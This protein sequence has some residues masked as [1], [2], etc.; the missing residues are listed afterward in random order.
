MK[1]GI[2]T[3]SYKPYV[4][5]VVRSIDTFSRE[6]VRRGHEIYVFAPRYPGGQEEN[7]NV[8]R[9]PSFHTPANPEFYIGLPLPWRAIRYA[10]KWSLD[11]IHVHSPFLLGRLGASFARRLKVPLVFTYHTLYDQYIHYFPFARGL[12]RHVV[13]HMAR[14]FCNRCDLVITPTGVIRNL[15]EG[16]G[17]RRP[18]VPIPTGIYPERFHAG[19]PCFLYENFGIPWEEKIL[20]FVGRIGKE[21]NLDFLFRVFRQVL[22]QHH[23][24]TLVLVGSGPEKKALETFAEELGINSKVIFTGLLPPDVVAGAY[25]SADLFVFPSVTETQGLVLLEA[26]AAGLPVVARAAFGSLAMVQ[27]GKTGFLCDEREEE[28]AARI[29]LLLENSSLRKQ[30]SEAARARA[31]RLSA[32]KMALRL[33]KAYLALL[34]GARDLLQDLAYEEI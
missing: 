32:E 7:G 33:E 28:F 30:M 26:M 25:R 16:Y 21:K 18:I 13:I 2:F 12:A 5:G 6:L 20:L 31:C 34:N 19:D 24:V 17:V 29:I 3:D 11:L 15:L 22:Q 8:Y 4:S 10:K 27:D 9:F 14:D 23:A 1:I